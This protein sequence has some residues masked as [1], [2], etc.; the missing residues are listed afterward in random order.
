MVLA[1]PV[2]VDWTFVVS[3]QSGLTDS[4]S[5]SRSSVGSG[6]G[7]RTVGSGAVLR[8][9][10]HWQGR[11]RDQSHRSSPKNFSVSA[12]FSFTSIANGSLFLYGEELEM[13]QVLRLGPS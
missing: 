6:T 9:H 4:V 5:C 7:A 1:S 12:P 3:P 8:A 11:A 10:P 2:A 13:T